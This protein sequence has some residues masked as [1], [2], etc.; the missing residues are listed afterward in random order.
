MH[1]IWVLALRPG[2]R[3]SSAIHNLCEFG[4]VLNLSE[5]HGLKMLGGLNESV[6]MVCS[7]A[8]SKHMH[9][10]F[11]PLCDFSAVVQK[12]AFEWSGYRWKDS[13]LLHS[14]GWEQ[15][16]TARCCTLFLP[17]WRVYSPRLLKRLCLVATNR[18]L[19]KWFS[20]PVQAY[21]GL[22]V[23][24]QMKTKMSYHF[25][26]IGWAKIKGSISCW[27]RKGIG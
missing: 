12:A 19:A 9:G 25:L 11:C 24:M 27:V 14:S 4:Q 16:Y 17:P 26:L 7:L 8:Y 23:K 18:L 13:Q 3:P 1:Q 2:F 10:G 15:I 22:T 6:Y 20:N 5:P 21:S